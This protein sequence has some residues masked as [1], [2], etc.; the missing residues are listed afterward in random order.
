M[1]STSVPA[2][3]A[4]GA[5]E[6]VGKGVLLTDVDAD[7]DGC[8]AGE[9]EAVV[10]VHIE[11]PIYPGHPH[12]VP[13]MQESIIVS[14]GVAEGVDAADC[15]CVTE[16]DG[17]ALVDGLCVADAVDTGDSVADG[18]TTKV[19]VQLGLAVGDGEGDGKAETEGTGDG[20]DE[21]DGVCDGE[22]EVDG[23]GDGEDEGDH[24]MGGT[25]PVTGA[26]HRPPRFS[27]DCP[28][29]VCPG[30]PIA[31]M[32]CEVNASRYRAAPS[33][34]SEPASKTKSVKGGNAPPFVFD[35]VA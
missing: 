9:S 23:V 32:T 28:S 22:D 1:F 15:V 18:E 31:S 2:T 16:A 14:E 10:E 30:A 12:H 35:T 13:P 24:A 3:E 8:G 34:R 5:D 26:V 6:G 21:V 11:V 19:G 27:P 17:V 20:E 33:P 7:G 4:E 25:A 29:L